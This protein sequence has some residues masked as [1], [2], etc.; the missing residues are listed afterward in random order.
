MTDTKQKNV[1]ESTGESQ[2]LPEIHSD[3]SFQKAKRTRSF[4]LRYGLAFVTCV[5]TLLIAI[6]LQSYSIKLNLT[7]L[8]IFAIIIPVWYGGRGPGL[9]VAIVFEMVTIFSRSIPPPD[10]SVGQFIFEC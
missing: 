8:I 10:I 1:E 5:V 4:L 2:V 3:K 9:L 7:I 6:L